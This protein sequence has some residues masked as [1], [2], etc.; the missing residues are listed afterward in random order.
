MRIITNKDEWNKLLESRFYGKY[1]IYFKYEYLD[2]WANWY[3]GI[4]EAI[5]WTNDA[6]EVF[7]THIV[8]DKE[9]DYNTSKFDLT[10]PYGYGGYLLND[11]GGLDEFYRRY[12]A[13]LKGRKEF[14]RL[15]PIFCDWRYI[16]PGFKLQLVDD[17]IVVDLTKKPEILFTEFKTDRRRNIR[18]SKRKRLTTNIIKSPTK[19]QIKKFSELYYNA[20]DLNNAGERYYFPLEFLENHFKYLDAVL[21]NA[22][23]DGEII[24]S[25]IFILGSDTIEYHLSGR[26]Y[27]DKTLCPHDLILWNMIQWANQ[28]GYRRLILGGGRGN[29]DTLYN[30]KRGFSKLT[31]PYYVGKIND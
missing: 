16:T 9:V 31:Y 6:S 25:S 24:G 15:H 7:W 20:M 18:K 28:N 4:P 11:H 30:F 19:E 5:Y 13:Y 22:E 1:D 27:S 26:D 14:I 12:L 23:K 8:L 29:N 2:L 17:I 10:T 21:V 3:G